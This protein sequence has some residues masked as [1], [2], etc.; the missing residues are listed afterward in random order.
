MTI[1][2]LLECIS[3][4]L[5]LFLVYFF[6][7]CDTKGF[8]FFIFFSFF[9]CVWKSSVLFCILH[10]TCETNPTFNMSCSLYLL[11]CK[12][13]FIWTIW[14]SEKLLPIKMSSL[15]SAWTQFVAFISQSSILLCHW[16]I[17]HASKVIIP[18]TNTNRRSNHCQCFV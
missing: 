15:F 5:L 2:L 17:T 1:L 11:N 18:M 13:L 14:H 12:C 9:W 10:T 3:K 7:V 4:T 6:L 8:S 16:L